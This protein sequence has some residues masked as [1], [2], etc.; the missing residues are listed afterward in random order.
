MMCLQHI[1]IITPKLKSYSLL[2]TP[3][4]IQFEKSSFSVSKSQDNV[5][6][7]F[8]RHHGTIGEV[9]VNLQY[10][11]GTAKNGLN[12]TGETR[13]KFG[14]GETQNVLKIPCHE[15]G[16]VEGDTLFK[17]KLYDPKGG[18][19]IENIIQTQISE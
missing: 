15:L 9:S 2:G 4:T 18:A 7:S 5:S 3:G 8:I 13:I 6:V 11:D 16:G 17:I 10:I 19:K 12:Y 14:H 1:F